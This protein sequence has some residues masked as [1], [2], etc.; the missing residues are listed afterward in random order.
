MEPL[1]AMVAMD[2]PAWMDP[3]VAIFF[4]AVKAFFAGQV[5]PSAEISPQFEIFPAAF[6]SKLKPGLEPFASLQQGV[7]EVV[8]GDRTAI[9]A[10]ASVSVPLV[11]KKRRKVHLERRR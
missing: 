3:A 10:T 5:I 1:L 4:A 11:D 9:R 7:Y 8:Y 2:D 6:T